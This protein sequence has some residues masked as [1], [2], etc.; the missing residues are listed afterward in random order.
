MRFAHSFCWV[1]LCFGRRIQLLKQGSRMQPQKLVDARRD[2]IADMAKKNKLS[3]SYLVR[4][5]FSSK[6]H[7]QAK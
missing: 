2:E 3:R 4:C 7:R 5:P 6:L 1:L